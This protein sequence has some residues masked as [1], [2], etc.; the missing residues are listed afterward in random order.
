[1]VEPGLDESSPVLAEVDVR[2][3]VIVLHGVFV[4]IFLYSSLL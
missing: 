4:L 3:D 2:D 1:L